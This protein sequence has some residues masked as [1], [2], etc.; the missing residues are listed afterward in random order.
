MFVLEDYETGRNQQ[1]EPCR[2]IS[3]AR[4]AAP[5]PHGP[6]PMMTIFIVDS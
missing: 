5:R 6:P 1:Y 2:R 4:Q 3:S